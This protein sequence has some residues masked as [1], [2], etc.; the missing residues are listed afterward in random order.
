[1]TKRLIPAVLL[2]AV[3]LP[4]HADFGEIARAIDRKAG[5]KRIWIPL[6]GVA[7]FAV[8][9]IQPEGVHDFQLAT[10]EGTDDVD[11]REMQQLMRTKLG[12]GF[13]P[14]VQVWSRKAGR[15]E[16]SFIYARPLPQRDDFELVILAHDD[17]DTTLV[18]VS[19]NADMLARRLNEPR[20]V[21]HIARR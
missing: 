20:H 17:S 19:V 13:K 1:M 12:P 21:R 11:P 15:K 6:L 8:R 9:V 4:L 14:L 10:F 18:R 2:F 7:R 3:A 16:W 5:V